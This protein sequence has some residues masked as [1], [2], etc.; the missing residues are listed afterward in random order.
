ME[1]PEISTRSRLVEGPIQLHGQR[2]TSERDPDSLLCHAWSR[3]GHCLLPLVRVPLIGS[4]SSY[5]DGSAAGGQN[6]RGNSVDRVKGALARAQN[7]TRGPDPRPLALA[8]GSC[9][10]ER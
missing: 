9:T 2:Q 1:N 6:S 4:S 7:P 8:P 5:P 3:L 10:I